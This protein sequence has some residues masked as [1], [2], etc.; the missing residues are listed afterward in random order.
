MS[1][2][3][4]LL[5]T[6]RSRDRVFINKGFIHIGFYIGSPDAA[7]LHA[8]DS[9]QAENRKVESTL[10]DMIE[11]ACEFVIVAQDVFKDI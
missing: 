6:G 9:Q 5:A 10:E 3:I 4:R 2:K 1:V 8:L 11:A 7:T